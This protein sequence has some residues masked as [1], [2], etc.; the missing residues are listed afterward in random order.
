MKSRTRIR[1]LFFILL[2]FCLGSSHLAT[3]P[4][5]A[6]AQESPPQILAPIGGGYSDIYAGFSRLAIANQ[7]AGIVRILVLPLP[8]ATNPFSITEAERQDNLKAAE[9]RRFQIEEAC[10]REAPELTCAAQL[11]PVFTRSEAENSALAQYFP[12]DLAAVFILGGD[13][14]IAMQVVQNT[15]LE[16]L[17]QIA[18]QRGVVIAGTSAGGGMLSRNMLGGYAENAAAGTSLN[19]GSIDL[20]N[21][22]TRRGLEFGLTEAVLDQHFFQRGRLGRL[23]SA[24][25]LPGAPGIGIGVDAYTGVQV[26]NHTKVEKVF[27][28]YVVTILDVQT[29]HAAENIRYKGPQNT[30]SIRNVLVHFLAPGP[31]SYDLNQRSHSLAPPPQQIYRNYAPLKLPTDAGPLVLAGDLSKALP[32]NSILHQFVQLSGNDSASI[33]VVATG[34]PSTSSAGRIAEKYAAAIGDGTSTLVLDSDATEPVT[35][36]P[37]VSGVVLVARD[38]SRLPVAQLESLRQAWLAGMPLLLDNAAAAVAGRYFSSHPPTPAEG[39]ELELA[40]QKTFLIGRTKIESGLGLLDMTVEPQLLD[41]NRWGRFFSL[42]YSHPDL[43]TIGLNQ[44]SALEI[45]TTGVR[46]LGTKPILVLDLSAASLELGENQGFVIANGLLDVYAPGETLEAV[47]ADQSAS[48]TPQATPIMV[49]PQH[50]ATPDQPAQP[51]Q[52]TSPTPPNIPATLTP[53][54]SPALSYL[55]TPTSA[56]VSSPARVPS[57]PVILFSGILL[58][59]LVAWIIWRRLSQPK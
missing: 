16:S 14:T 54:V 20:W 34:F 9:E 49:T 24:I 36:P 12:N 2:F 47:P 38:Q 1:R 7:Q 58:S 22:P 30:L 23:L 51:M 44:D 45:T 26:T 50:S 40:V 29:Y 57:W 15:P 59:S 33:L 37:N 4:A 31:A 53:T 18:Y 8:Y 21:S 56:P 11:A 10:K 55:A 3:S 41:D 6:L 43:L 35:I 32:G 27:G 39:E 46:A 5:P 48:Y 25:S 19:F 52:S 17:L 42:A 13:Q 28:L